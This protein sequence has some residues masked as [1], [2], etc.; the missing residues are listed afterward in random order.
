MPSRSFTHYWSNGTWSAYRTTAARGELVDYAASNQFRE[1]GLTAGDSLYIVTVL[2]GALYLLTRLQVAA[3]CGVEEAAQQLGEEPE[4][5]WPADDFAV[6]AAAVP[7]DFERVV[8]LAIAEQLRFLAGDGEPRPLKFRAE[9]L[10]DQQTL[11]GVRELAPDSAALLDALLPPLL[12]LH[13]AG[14]R[15]AL[16]R[17]APAVHLPEEVPDAR[18]GGLRYRE[19]AV[20]QITVNAYERNGRARQVCIDHWGCACVACGL[21]F[22][23]RYGEVAAGYIH[24]HHLRPLASVGEEYVLDPVADLVPVC[25]NCHAVM[26]MRADAPYTVEEIGEFIRDQG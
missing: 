18:Q 11:R 15:A 6:A 26:H 12:P 9:G 2:H 21:D 19:G 24:V 23:A 13:L 20:V 1:R 7:S 10:L 14:R 3:V 17:L 4:S 5:L 16:D 25:P 22:G 8:P